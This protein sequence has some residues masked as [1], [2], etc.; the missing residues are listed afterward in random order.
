MQSLL[1]LGLL[2][3]VIGTDATNLYHIFK[4]SPYGHEDMFLARRGKEEYVVKLLDKRHPNEY[5]LMTLDGNIKY[6]EMSQFIAK[7]YS[8]DECNINIKNYIQYRKYLNKRQCMIFK[9]Y[10]S[11]ALNR[12]DTSRHLG[13][14]MYQLLRALALLD[15]Y[16]IIHNDIKLD[17]LFIT[18]DNDICLGDF[19]MS[20]QHTHTHTHIY[21]YTYT[22]TLHY[23]CT[24]T[25]LN[26]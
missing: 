11:N 23:F 19:G 20:V 18:E 5:K 22:H 14:W 3:V 12:Y 7:A 8:I 16:N 4:I 13:K 6:I 1:L 10:K 25:Y 24:C 26:L 2:A 15:A 21:I 9:K 17:N